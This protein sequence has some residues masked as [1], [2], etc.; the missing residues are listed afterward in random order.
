ML[1]LARPWLVASGFCDTV[2]LSRN[3]GTAFTDFGRLGPH[4]ATLSVRSF[5]SDAIDGVISAGTRRLNYPKHYWNKKYIS[6]HVVVITYILCGSA[7]A[8]R[9]LLCP[10]PSCD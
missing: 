5:S 8:E 3:L 9:I 4:M 7:G 2:V 6:M 10:R 1:I